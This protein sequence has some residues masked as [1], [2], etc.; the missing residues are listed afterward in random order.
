VIAHDI[1]KVGSSH[2]WMGTEDW[3]ALLY[4]TRDVDNI[5]TNSH[6]HGSVI[7]LRDF[8]SNGGSEAT[9]AGGFY[10]YLPGYL[11]EWVPELGACCVGP[12]CTFLTEPI[13]AS[14]DGTFV[15]QDTA[16]D[17]DPCSLLGVEASEASA[18]PTLTVRPNPSTDDATL[19]YTLP[20][21]GPVRIAVFDPA[22][23]HVRTLL[24]DASERGDV[25]ITWDGR[26][27]IERHVPAGI[28]FIRLVSTCGAVTKPLLVVP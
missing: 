6:L 12:D 9:F 3:P 5:S 27:D 8:V 28:Y 11:Q 23:R 22:G 1:A 7:T 25:A 16:C 13:C 20:R 21:P 17:P 26:D 4:L 18:R 10:R 24:A 2:A 19:R 15:G 14:Y